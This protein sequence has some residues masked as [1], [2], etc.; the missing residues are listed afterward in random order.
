MFHEQGIPQPVVDLFFHAPHEV[1]GAIAAH[2]HADMESW[3][4]VLSYAE[5]AIKSWHGSETLPADVKTAFRSGDELSTMA[6]V[7]S[8]APSVQPEVMR[9]LADLRTNEVR[10]DLSRQFMMDGT[11]PV[12][13]HHALLNG[14]SP[15]LEAALASLSDGDAVLEMLRQI[16]VTAGL[17]GAGLLTFD[18][19]EQA[20]VRSGVFDELSSTFEFEVLRHLNQSIL[21]PPVSDNQGHPSLRTQVKPSSQEIQALLSEIPL[22]VQDRYWQS[23]SDFGMWAQQNL[24]A[25]Q[26]GLTFEVMNDVARASRWNDNIELNIRPFVGDAVATA[27][28]N[29]DDGALENALLSLPPSQQNDARTLVADLF[30][31]DLMMGLATQMNGLPANIYQ[32]LISGNLTLVDDWVQTLPEGQRPIVQQ[33]LDE[34][35]QTAA[36]ASAMIFLPHTPA[37][38]RESF[39]SGELASVAAQLPAHLT[40]QLDLAANWALSKSN[41]QVIRPQGDEH[42]LGGHFSHAN[43]DVSGGAAVTIRGDMSGDLTINDGAVSGDKSVVVLDDDGIGTWTL[44]QSDDHRYSWEAVNLDEN[45]QAMGRVRLTHVESVVLNGERITLFEQP[46][47]GFSIGDIFDAALGIAAAAVSGPAVPVLLKGIVAGLGSINQLAQGR[48]SPFDFVGLG[49]ST[50]VNPLAGGA[51]SATD[52]V[53]EGDW[54]G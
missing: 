13:V 36:Q 20:A 47:S 52:N 5:K 42:Q 46:K 6:A 16:E 50:L 32:D 41:P 15:Q 31:Q 4:S 17:Y 33:Q 29:G 54:L 37:G 39:V 38:L 1:V 24:P 51:I 23:P 2:P 44:A 40:G 27:L 48:I 30:Y 43:Y 11:Y 3:L 19:Q 35:A 45:G 14:Q 12:S 7:A 21:P 28:L 22:E 18:P 49:V 26:A 53:A 25:H 9:L 34:L 10:T 8:L